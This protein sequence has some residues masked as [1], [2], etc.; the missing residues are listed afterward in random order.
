MRSQ[1]EAGR[2]DDRMRVE[3]RAS[4]FLIADLTHDN[5]ARSHRRGYAEGLGKPVIYTW[6]S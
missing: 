3:I 6:P 1:P 4:D 2:I 5:L